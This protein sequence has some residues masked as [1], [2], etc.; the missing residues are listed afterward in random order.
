MLFDSKIQ[1]NIYTNSWWSEPMDSISTLQIINNKSTEHSKFLNKEML[2]VY[3]P[4]PPPEFN[5]E[6]LM[7]GKNNCENCSK[8]INSQNNHIL[9]LQEIW[10]LYYSH[11]QLI[12]DHLKKQSLSKL[13]YSLD[14]SDSATYTNGKSKCLQIDDKSVSNIDTIL[15]LN[16]N[17]NNIDYQHSVEQIYNK[18]SNS[19]ENTQ[20][21]SSFNTKSNKKSFSIMNSISSLKA[22][23]YNS[24]EN[25]P[26]VPKMKI[27]SIAS[28][29][30]KTNLIK[31]KSSK[32]KNQRYNLNPD[33]S[34]ENKSLKMNNE[35]ISKSK[36][37]I[38][39]N[40]ALNTNLNRKDAPFESNVD[41][42]I[43]E[44]NSFLL[45]D[46]SWIKVNPMLNK[47]SNEIEIY[48][49]WADEDHKVLY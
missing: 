41:K 1:N 34:I 9:K 17:Q 16:K 22:K 24:N 7:L 39:N 6:E 40:F 27:D 4:P 49:Q 18:L 33:L 2:S 44:W 26:N 13:Q 43:G 11:I 3:L 10:R 31:V 29:S 30:E 48:E 5:I 25:N 47:N 14:K 42:S 37:F 12:N 19:D 38:P 36:K 15:I 46:L 21:R 32:T 45:N 23:Q 8:I 35:S 20:N 28:T